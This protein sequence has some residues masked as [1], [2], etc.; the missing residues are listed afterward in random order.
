MVLEAYDVA[1]Q[2][3]IVENASLS[4]NAMQLNVCVGNTS[5]VARDFELCVQLF[6]DRLISAP[7]LMRVTRNGPILYAD[8]ATTFDNIAVYINFTVCSNAIRTVLLRHVLSNSAHTE[9]R[10]PILQC[11][12][13]NI[14]L[15]KR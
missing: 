11:V 6:P 14:K 2:Y 4:V 8:V 5:H 12:Q 13:T 7:L 9:N 15:F 10:R 3:I 1:V